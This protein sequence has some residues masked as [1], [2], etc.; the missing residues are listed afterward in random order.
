MKNASPRPRTK[1]S[2]TEGMIL[3][4]VNK[5]RSCWDFHGWEVMKDSFLM[6]NRKV[7][8]YSDFLRYYYSNC[9]RITLQR[10]AL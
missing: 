6:S 5:G 9:S 1:D 8:T 7:L 2:K 3:D 4:P 10:E